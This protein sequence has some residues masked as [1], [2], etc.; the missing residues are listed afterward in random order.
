MLTHKATGAELR[1][2]QCLPHPRSLPSSDLS[3]RQA[4]AIFMQP[5]G[6]AS[7]HSSNPSSTEGFWRQTAVKR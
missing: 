6:G 4:F 7:R 1:G 2:M 3:A 5:G